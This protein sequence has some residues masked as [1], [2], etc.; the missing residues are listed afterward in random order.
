MLDC[1]HCF[2]FSCLQAVKKTQVTISCPICKQMT[3]MKGRL[4]SN[5]KNN[6][7]IC[8]LLQLQQSTRASITVPA[9]PDPE[10]RPGLGLSV[11]MP[12][13]AHIPCL[14][15]VILPSNNTSTLGGGG[16][17]GQAAFAAAAAANNGLVQLTLHCPGYVS[18]I[19]CLIIHFWKKLFDFR[20]A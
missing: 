11:L 8:D 9:D 18:Y 15:P 2:C 5:L 14:S 17:G 19:C 20:K 16:G 10:P 3:N 4:I 13:P 7:V 1:H 12:P 6:F